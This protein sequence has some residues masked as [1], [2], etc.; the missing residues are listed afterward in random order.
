MV[1]LQRHER[2]VGRE[3]HSFFWIIQLRKGT[4]DILDESE[5]LSA[6]VIYDGGV[7]ETEEPDSFF[8]L[9]GFRIQIIDVLRMW[10]QIVGSPFSA[11]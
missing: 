3:E 7:E 9:Q 2:M 1:Q 8:D 6:D 4:H 11:K 10:D 5:K